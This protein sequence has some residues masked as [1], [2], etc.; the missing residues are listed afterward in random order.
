MARPRQPIDPQGESEILLKAYKSQKPSWER[1][2]MTAVKL[3]MEGMSNLQISRTLGRSHATIQSWLNKFREGGLCALLDKKK[4][5]GPKGRFT[6]EMQE[7]MSQ[8]L[9]KGQW[10]TAHEA[11][12]WLKKNYNIKE[13]SMRSIYNYMGK[14]GGRLKATRPCNPKKNEEAEAAFRVTLAEKMVD[15]KIDP[16]KRV[17]LWVYDEMR[18]GLLPLT[19]KMWCLRGVRAIAPS[20]QRYQN[21]YLYGALEVGGDS[22]SEFLF[23]PGLNKQWD[24][25]FL[26]Q[27]ANSSPDDIHVVIG[28]GAGFHHKAADEALPSNIK[29]ITLPAYS[30]ELNPAEKLWDIVKDGI[31][32]IDW[33]DLQAI[34]DKITDRIRPYWEGVDRVVSLIGNGYLTSELNAT[35]S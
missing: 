25:G 20:R 15:F 21:G 30:P 16:D 28:D 1:E 34:E 22:C 23:T 17:R 7:A 26:R 8:E 9:A 29:I 6:S 35:N 13:V 4:G 12:A 19:R 3:A 33:P 18:Y 2:R 24:Q 27:I 32:N 5:N 11:Y 10:R 14:S 31:C